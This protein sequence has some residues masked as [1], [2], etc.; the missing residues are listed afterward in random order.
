VSPGIT[1]VT[2]LIL[3]MGLFLLIENLNFLERQDKKSHTTFPD[4]ER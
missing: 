2:V 4:V 3:A 1:L